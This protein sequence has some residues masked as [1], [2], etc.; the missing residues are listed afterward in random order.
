MTELCQFLPWDTDFFGWRT[1]R[2]NCNRLDHAKTASILNWCEANR[3][4]CLY[5]QADADDPPTVRLAEASGFQ[6]VEVRVFFERSLKDW[7][8]GNRTQFSDKFVLRQARPEDLPELI[9]IAGDMFKQTRFYFDDHFPENKRQDL[10]R[11]WVRRSFTGGVDLGL[12]A[13][14][15]GLPVGF[16]TAKIESDGVTGT[17]DLAGVKS[18]ATRMGIAQELIRSSLDW[19]AGRGVESVW[20]PTQGRNVATQRAF[21]RCGFI[22]RDVQLYYHRWF[23]FP[24]DDK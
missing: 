5:F 11:A 14:I 23:E 24:A 17:Y 22:T 13:D 18:T 8:P 19:F 12:V 9:E 1:A 20:F 10:Y 4:E 6:L 3:I 21:Q 15:G 16:I 2:V 7:Q